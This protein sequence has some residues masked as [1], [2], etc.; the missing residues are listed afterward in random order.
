[1]RKWEQQ[2]VYDKR[3]NKDSVDEILHILFNNRKLDTPEQI[4]QF[5]EPQITEVTLKSVGVNSKI[6]D[7]VVARIKRAIEN[8][9]QIAIY[10]DYDVDGVTSTAIL[11]ETIHA[12]GG[13]VLPYIPHRIDEGY[14]LSVKGINNLISLQTPPKLIITV[15]NGIVAH[16]AVSYA[17]AQDIEV[18]ITDHHVKADT[19]PKAFAILH[20]TKLCGAGL[21]YLLSKELKPIPMESDTYLELAALGT[22]AD[23]VPLTE[24]NRTIVRYG[25]ARLRDTKRPGLRAL[26]ESASLSKDRFSVYDVSFIISPRLNAAGRI[27]SAMDSL[28]LL[29]TKDPNRGRMLAEKLEHINRERQD[30]LKKSADHAKDWF[31]RDKTLLKNILFIAHA[32]YQEGIIGLIAGKLVEAYYRPSIVISLGEKHSKASARSVEGFNMIEFLRKHEDQFLS[33][34]GH[35]MAAGFSIETAKVKVLQELLENSSS[36]LLTDGPITKILHIDCKIPFSIISTELYSAIQT[37]SPF[38]MGN[39]EPIFCSSNVVIKK[40]RL[41]GKSQNHLRLSIS[42]EEKIFDA[43]GFNLVDKFSGLKV[44]DKIELAYV[45]EENV[46]NGYTNLQLRIIDIK[47]PE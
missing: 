34:G 30:M 3:N 43:I 7:K 33:L 9:E 6:T 17:N 36:G 37:L 27:D 46:W 18:I 47:M 41:M 31:A 42:N 13:L 8:K 38:G 20:C 44:G 15:D 10:G 19:L 16:E 28:R 45:I 35:P 14:G 32:E 2:Y 40:I 5:L 12:L 39:P 23:L 26:Y 1:M 11:W 24:A 25:L 4:R 21:A 29:C 22:I